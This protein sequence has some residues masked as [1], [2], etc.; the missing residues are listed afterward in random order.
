MKLKSLGVLLPVLVL[1]LTS[2]A[3]RYTFKIDAISDGSMSNSGSFYLVSGNADMKENDLRFKEA[4]EYVATALEGKGYTRAR[5]IARADMLVEVSFAVSEP[6][7]V[8]DVRHYPETYWA[9]GLAYM[10]SLPIYNS[11]G[12]VIAY[13]NR[14][15]YRPPRSYTRWED[16]ISTSTVYQKELTLTAYDNRLGASVSDPHQLWS[17]TVSNL[18][19]SENLRGYLPYLV[20]AALPYVGED[21]GSQVFMDLDRDDPQAEFIRNPD[22]LPTES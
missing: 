13:E 11:D 5:E 14:S 19:Y 7:D 16:R 18:D 6:K 22:G 9:P 2:C 3:T 15:I 10:I 8:V 12:V 21:T 4:A 1:L 17:V 20:A